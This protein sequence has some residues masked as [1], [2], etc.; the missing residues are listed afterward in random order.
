M[1]RLLAYILLL[2]LSLFFMLFCGKKGP[3][4]P[5]LVK[6]PQ[7]VETLTVLQRGEEFIIN[8]KN[9]S[10]YIDGSPLAE[11]KELEIWKLQE[12]KEKDQALAPV[13]TANFT[14][15]S[16]LMLVIP[17]E[18]ISD[19]MI[20]EDPTSPN[21]EHVF[22]FKPEDI[23]TQR[24]TI[25]LKVVDNR[26]KNSEFSQLIS[27]EPKMVPKPP[28]ELAA[29]VHKDKIAVTWKAAEQVDDQ[30]A[31][32]DVKGYNIYRYTEA[33]RP[34]KLNTL[35]LTVT[36]FED[37]L[38]SFGIRYRYF[39]RTSASETPPFLESVNSA[40][41]EVLAA[42]TFP[43]AAPTGLSAIAGEGE[44]SLSWNPNQEPDLTGYKVWRKK[45]AE[46]DY[47]LLTAEIQEG[48]SYT[49]SVVEKNV[50][51]DYTVTAYDGSD[52]Q[53]AEAEKVSVILPGR[54]HENIPL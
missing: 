42:D 40:E 35:L 22:S 5:P 24:F 14:E 19:Y 7:K 20:G 45:R 52:N 13:S 34:Q 18:K 3:I 27:V 12:P 10:R 6:V 49:D 32:A 46:T 41:F 15:N 37:K 38:F 21:F 4:L 8:W 48:N 47:Q 2:L 54:M 36:S 29:V 30:A 16:S 17:G 11:I 39:V 33:N 51:Y 43:P 1:K 53:S 50:L 9:P 44:I 25:G 28:L 31:Q 23:A 26:G